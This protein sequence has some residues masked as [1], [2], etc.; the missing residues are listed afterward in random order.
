M[1]C[2]PRVGADRADAT[3]SIRHDEFNDWWIVRFAGKVKAGDTTR[4]QFV[5]L[6]V[7]GH[8]AE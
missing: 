8:A 3:P 7:V 6:V 4:D 5:D 2:L 1:L